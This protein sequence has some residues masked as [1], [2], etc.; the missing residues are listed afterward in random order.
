MHIGIVSDIHSDAEALSRVLKGMSA[1]DAILCPGD[2]VSEYEF[3]AET[4]ALLADHGVHCIQGNHEAVLFGG[5]NPDYLESAVARSRRS[6]WRSSPM[7]R[8]RAS[9]TSAACGY[10]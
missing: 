2:A 4:V 6:P 8:P 7:R 9:S 5:R 3:C 1:M 10:S